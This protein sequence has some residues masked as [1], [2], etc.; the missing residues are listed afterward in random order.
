MYKQF[1]LRFSI[2]RVTVELKIILDYP[3]SFFRYSLSYLWQSCGNVHG[4][5][6]N[7]N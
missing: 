3:V 5:W 2:Q 7:W 1:L 6:S 4:L